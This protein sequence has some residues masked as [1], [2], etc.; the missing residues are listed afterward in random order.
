MDDVDA[1]NHIYRVPGGSVWRRRSRS[2]VVPLQIE[3]TELRL[4]VR[5]PTDRVRALFLC[6]RYKGR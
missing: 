3:C 6:V 1:E 5:Y 4:D 2:D